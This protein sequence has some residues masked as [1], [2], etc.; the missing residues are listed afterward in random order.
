MTK[1][2]IFLVLLTSF[3]IQSNSVLAQALRIPNATNQACTAGR[4]VGVTEMVITWNAPGVKNREGKIWGTDVVYYGTSVLGFGSNVNSPWRAGADE[5]T[6]MAF[7]TDVSINGQKL[8][9]GKYSFFMEVYPDSCILIFND[10]AEGWGSYFYDQSKDVLRVTTRQQKG[11]KTSNERLAY[12]F[13]NQT[14]QTV[15]IALEWEYWRIPFTVAVDL[16]GTT[17]H[18]IQKQMSGALGFDPPSLQAAATWCLNNNVNYDQA[19]TWITSATDPFLGGVNNFNALSTRSG[20]LK[21]LGKKEEA[22][23]ILLQAIDN[24]SSIEL[25]QYGRQLLGQK[26]IDEAVVVFEKNFKKFNGAWPTHVGLMR[27]YSAQGNLKKA[28]EHAKIGL[29]QAPD[30]VNKKN[31]ESAIK[32]LESGKPL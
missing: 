21:K 29:Q 27:G 11:L 7:S 1:L 13:G 10:N 23:K 3:L 26:K 32:T 18:Q 4:T 16:T 5:C 25:H 17:L 14:D 19:L 20:I 28:L 30:E 22:D 8:Q 6:T 31:L 12:S 2:P 9:A 15:E 24:A